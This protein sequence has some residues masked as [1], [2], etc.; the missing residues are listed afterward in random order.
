ML[1]LLFHDGEESTS[2]DAMRSEYDKHLEQ[3]EDSVEASG[4]R[5]EEELDLEVVLDQDLL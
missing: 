4:R 3:P 1:P 2:L 5:D